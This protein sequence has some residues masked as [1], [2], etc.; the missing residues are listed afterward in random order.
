[1]KKRS[2]KARHAAQ[3]GI[4]L[5]GVRAEQKKLRGAEI[6]ECAKVSIP[7]GDWSPQFLR[8]TC[9]FF[10]AFRGRAPFAIPA[11]AVADFDALGHTMTLVKIGAAKLGD[12][13]D[14]GRKVI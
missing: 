2:V 12:I 1:M 7:G 14:S 5:A 10:H 9:N 6:I 11:F 3:I 13:H 4:L 8:L